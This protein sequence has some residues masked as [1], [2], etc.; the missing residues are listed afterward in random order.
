MV[1]CHVHLWDVATQQRGWITG[2]WEPSQEAYLGDY[3]PLKRTF[4]LDDLLPLY[5]AARVTKVVHVQADWGGG[6]QVDET[7][8]VNG[9]ALAAGFPIAI[10]AG[11]DLRASDAR[12][13]LERHLD[14]GPVRGVRMLSYYENLF[15]DDAF[16]HGL[17]L[18]EE[19]GLLF[20][21]GVMWDR[22][23]DALALARRRPGVQFVLDHAAMPIA[24]DPDSLGAWRR[25]MR[26]VASCENVVVKIS[27]LAERRADGSARP[28]F[29]RGVR[30][31]SRDARIQLARRQPVRRV[32][33]AY[34]RLRADHRRAFGARAAVS[35]ARDSRARL[36]LLRAPGAGTG[37]KRA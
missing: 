25:G 20:E 8:W 37:C 7:R 31:V 14:A 34:R 23:N 33:R 21:I 35:V 24:R 32:R 18:L 11:A 10:V 28:R 17:D 19:L 27:G 15:E 3:T 1:D 6:D 36:S 30:A 16:L 5:A 26:E 4:L 2:D 13:E 12:D 9:L 29:A 22:L